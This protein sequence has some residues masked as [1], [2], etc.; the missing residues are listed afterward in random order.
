MRRALALLLTLLAALSVQAAVYRCEVDGK[1]V[2]TDKPCAAGATPH[3]L[4]QFGTMPAA[5]DANL[6]GDRDQRQEQQRKS[7]HKDDA[8]WLKAHEARKAEEVRM[9]AAIAEGQ[10]LK[11]MSADQVRRA[12]G[13]PDEIER[14]SGVEEWSY[15]SGK[16]RQTVVIENGRVLRI[17]GKKK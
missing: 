5:R 15:G 1:P 2:Y 12:L 9:N 8:D 11:D 6:A 14:K 7:R 16:T 13:S 17:A 10:V 3:P 4:P